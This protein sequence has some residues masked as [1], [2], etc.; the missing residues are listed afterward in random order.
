[1]AKYIKYKMGNFDFNLYIL[2]HRNNFIIWV[3][4]DK[5]IIKIFFIVEEKVYFWNFNIIYSLFS[6]YRI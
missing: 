6:I 1:M 2:R 5:Y 4:F 3:K